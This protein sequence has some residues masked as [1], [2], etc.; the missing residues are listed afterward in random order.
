MLIFVDTNVW[1]PISVADLIL[2]SVEAGMFELAWSDESMGE[3]ERIVVSVKGL[4]PA[5]ARVFIEQIEATAPAGRVD[6]RTYQHLE[7]QMIGRDPGDHVF[8]AA[9]QGGK[10]DVFLTENISDFP[11][12]DLGPSAKALRPDDFFS[13]FLKNFPLEFVTLIKEMSA[14]LKRPPL[15]EFDVLERLEKSGM[16]NFAKEMRDLLA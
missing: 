8:S 9:V 10:I 5:K 16:P 4:E 2:R 7:S 13:E 3:L 12:G 14:N 6:P 1:Y 15:S 11:K